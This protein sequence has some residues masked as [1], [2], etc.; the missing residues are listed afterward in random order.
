MSNT[1]INTLLLLTIILLVSGA[2]YYL[3]DVQ[4]TQELQ[5][6]QETRRLAELQFAEAEE[7]LQA[8]AQTEQIA[9]ETI[10]KWRA[11]YKIVPAMIETPDVIEYLE[12]LTARGFEQIDFDLKGVTRTA[13]YSYYTFTVRGTAYFTSL[14]RLVWNLENTRELYHV[15]NL[16]LRHVDIMDE[17][18]TTGLERR[19]SMVDFTFDLR[20]YFGG[21]EGLSAPEEDLLPVPRSLLPAS[22]PVHNSF[23]P[24][25]RTELPPNDKGLVDLSK[26]TLLS[27]LGKR[28]VL[29]DASGVHEL[30]EGDEVYL[31]TIV[32]V[33]PINIVVRARLTRGQ[34]TEMVELRIDRT[35]Q[36]RGADVRVQPIDNNDSDRR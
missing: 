23:Y 34:T 33:D 8:E 29:E 6:L 14:Y 10:R 31:G 4:Q 5:A 3:T 17:N 24:L 1:V 16:S 9:D 32:D 2:G 15:R 27:I 36:S 20:A 7:L 12:S 26:A 21:S 35:I 22:A 19:L 28:A 25:V 13:S 11:R 18:P 30:T